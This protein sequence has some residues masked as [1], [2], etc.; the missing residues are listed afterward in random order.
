MAN[1]SFATLNK[2]NLKPLK[3]PLMNLCRLSWLKY[4]FVYVKLTSLMLDLS[5]WSQCSV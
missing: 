5:R 4:A 1:I 2:H 3:V